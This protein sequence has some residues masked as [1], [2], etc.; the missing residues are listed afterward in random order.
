MKKFV[1]LFLCLMV[2]GFPVAAVEDTAMTVAQ[3]D[4]LNY[5]YGY[6]LGHEFA[7]SGLLLRPEALF[8][9]IYTALDKAE[10]EFS[11]EAM[12]EFMGTVPTHGAVVAVEQSVLITDDVDAANYSFGFGLGERMLQQ[13]VEFHADALSD[14]IYDGISQKPPR[15]SEEIM[16][17]LLIPEQN[18]TNMADETPKRFRLPGQKYISDNSSKKGVVMTASGLQYEILKVGTG[19]KT[20]KL[21]D[22]VL[23]KYTAKTIHGNV[24]SST[25]QNGNSTPEEIKVNK[26]IAGW[27]EALLL[28]H[29]G[30]RWLLTIP[31]NIAYRDTGPMGGQTIII[32]L[33]LLDIYLGYE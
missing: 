8:Q 4:D 17:Q 11:R 27:K 14:G 16:A 13:Q 18:I 5:S 25:F 31:T 1:W 33:K 6:Q 22:S 9:A 21:T 10:P 2:F 15:L 24:F 3:M 19:K 28:M 7:A 12:A 23:I 32:D 26:V 20:P 29:E 30:D